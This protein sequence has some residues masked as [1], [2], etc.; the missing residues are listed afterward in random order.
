MTTLTLIPLAGLVCCLLIVPRVAHPQGLPAYAP[1]NP[2]ADSRTPLGFEPYRSARPRRWR[3]GLGLDYASAIE[4]AVEP[5][6]SYDLDAEILRLRFGVVRDLGP[7]GF[8]E[9]EGGIGGGYA[10]FLDRAIDWYHGLLGVTV[11]ERERRPR[12]DFLY[13]IDLPDG[14]A[15]ER[16]PRDLF[17]GDLRLAA[18][19]RHTR[20]LQ[21]VAA[22]VLP[23]STAQEGY[24]RDAV[25]L[26]LITTIRLP[27][28]EPLIYEGSLGLGY[29]PTRGDLARYQRTAFVSGSSGLRWRVW[30]RQSIYA[31]LFVH[32]P[33]Y[34]DTTLRSLDR[35][36]L[37]LDFGWILASRSG[38]EWRVGLTE[39]LE[40]GGPGI[41]LVFR[42]GVTR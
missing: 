27:L 14:R 28:A 32:S 39:D 42:L 36:E 40:P 23:V 6:A 18:G 11:E 35:Q 19:V 17:L 10:G 9:L 3:V 34:H 38:Q 31:N 16:R 37:S 26:G 24:G 15:V 2:A 1:I 22:L 13:R 12:G 8:V 21:T 5:G 7:A 30:G 25:A 20:H 29:S 33:Y 4:H 41:D